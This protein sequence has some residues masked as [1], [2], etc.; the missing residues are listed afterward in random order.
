MRPIFSA[1]TD[2]AAAVIHSPRSI[3]PADNAGRAQ[4]RT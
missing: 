1:E 4:R 3:G 2:Q